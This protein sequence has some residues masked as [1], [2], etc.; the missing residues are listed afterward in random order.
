[1]RHC[2]VLVGWHS[3]SSIRHMNEITLP[4]AQLVMEWVTIFGY[5]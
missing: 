2:H 4:S 5:I 3:G 1:M